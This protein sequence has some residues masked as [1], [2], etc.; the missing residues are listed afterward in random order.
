MVERRIAPQIE[1]EVNSKI[2]PQ[3]NF[4]KKLSI[5]HQKVKSSVQPKVPKFDLHWTSK[6]SK[7]MMIGNNR[8]MTSDTQNYQ[9]M[10]QSRAF[11][12]VQTSSSQRRFIKTERPLTQQT[13]S[14][15]L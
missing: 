4:A 15:R 6:N 1:V 8:L 14:A 10:N 3:R 5:A 12:S 9:N 11:R 13:S 2:F 7:N